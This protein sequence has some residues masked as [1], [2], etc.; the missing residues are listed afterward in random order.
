MGEG[1]CKSRGSM[2]EDV[3]D[4][5][6]HVGKSLLED[7]RDGVLEGTEGVLSVLGEL[8]GGISDGGTMGSSAQ[9]GLESAGCLLQGLSNSAHQLLDSLDMRL[10][11]V[12]ETGSEGTE[13]VSEGTSLGSWVVRQ[14]LSEKGGEICDKL[15]LEIVRNGVVGSYDLVNFLDELRSWHGGEL[16]GESLELGEGL[17]VH[18]V[19]VVHLLLHDAL[20]GISQ[21]FHFLEEITQ[22]SLSC[23]GVCGALGAKSVHGSHQQTLKGL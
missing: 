3:N 18:P 19:H 10:E 1:L 12:G 16:R 22:R 15:I 5:W 14:D 20:G 9:A 7:V 13:G 4:V 11:E 17:G 23:S 21:G 6:L 2:L 8:R